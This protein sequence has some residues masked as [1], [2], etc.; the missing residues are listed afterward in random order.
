[1]TQNRGSTAKQRVVVIG[2]GIVGSVL[3]F[4]LSRRQVDLTV[5]DRAQPGSG[6]SSH[7]FAWLNSFGK[8]PVEY[9]DL[10]RQ[11]MHMWDRLSRRL[12]ADIGLR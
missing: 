9:H 3:A 7:S 8:E 4:N 1:M 10:N 5:I 6:A 11:S 2:A 12:S